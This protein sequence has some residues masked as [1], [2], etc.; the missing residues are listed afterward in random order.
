MWTVFRYSLTRL[1]GQILGWGIG[2][3]ILGGYLINFAKTFI[4]VEQQE[5]LRELFA[6]YPQELIAF[7]G[8]MD[9]LFTPSGFLHIEFFSYMPLILGIFAILTGSGLLVGDEESGVLDLV[10]A[11]P[12]SR[13]VYFWGRV[14]AF[15]LAAVLILLITWLGFIIVIPST[16]MDINPGAMAQPFLALFSVLMLFGG[17]SIL[18]SMLLPSRRLTA[19]VSGL[20]LVASFFITGLS[21][22]DER[23]ETVSKFSPLNY[24]QGGYAID[25]INWEWILGLLAF[26]LL[27]IL[28]AWL[29]FWRRDIRVGGEGGW[30]LPKLSLRRNKE[31]VV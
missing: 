17:L 18:L 19:M 9:D 22:L 12:I 6:I 24:Y 30:G 16:T 31:T 21:S 20:L 7:F 23:L 1:R 8:N 26:S 25:V 2:L 29:G 3:A 13:T 15:T 10:M 11:Y 14:L 5:A 27:F 4:N 28:L